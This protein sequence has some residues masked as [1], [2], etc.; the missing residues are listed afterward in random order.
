VPDD[1]VGI[2][3][4][5]GGAIVW[6]AHEDIDP[7][8]SREEMPDEID[9]ELTLNH[10]AGSWQTATIAA[11]AVAYEVWSEALP[12][13][14]G[15]GEAGNIVGNNLDTTVSSRAT[16]T[17]VDTIDSE[18]ENVL[19][20]ADGV[21]ISATAGV[22]GV[23]YPTGTRGQPSS[24]LTDATTIATNAG[25][26][27]F[28]FLDD[29]IYTLLVGY[30]DW[31]FE[32]ESNPSV[33]MNGQVLTGSVFHTGMFLFGQGQPIA[34]FECGFIAANTSG[35]FYRCAI[36]TNVNVIA[37]TNFI[38]C[39]FFGTDLDGAAGTITITDGSGTLTLENIAAGTHDI[40]N[41]NGLLTLN[42]NCVGGTINISGVTALV[43][44]SAGAT[45]NERDSLVNIDTVEQ[46]LAGIHGAGL[47]EGT[48]PAAIDALLTLNHGAGSWQSATVSPSAVAHE[49]WS[50]LLPGSYN[51]GEA[52]NIVG[53]NLDTNVG[54]RSVPGDQMDLVNDAVDANSLA[55]SA[56]QEIDTELTLQ[57]GAGSWQT[58][59]ITVSGVAYE[60]WSELLPGAYGPGEAGNIVGNNLDT[61]VGSRAVPGDEMALVDDAITNAKYDE[62][63]AYPLES[64]DSGATQVART[65]AD[66]DTL[67]TLSDQ[68]DGVVSDIG[69]IS[70]QIEEVLAYADGIYISATTGSGGTSYPTGTRGDPSS[71]IADATTLANTYG[72]RK[73]IFVDNSS[74]TLPQA[75]TDWRFAAE[76]APAINMNGQTL[77]GSIFYQGITL[78]GAGTPAA[79][80]E[81]VL[82]SANTAGLFFRCWFGSS[83]AATGTVEAV[84]CSY[85]NCD[86][87]A[88]GNRNINVYQGNGRLT[89]ENKTSGTHN[90]NDFNG[91]LTLQNTC[92]GGTIIVTGVGNITDN[93]GAGCTVNVDGFVNTELIDDYLAVT[94]G[95]GTGS[96]ETATP[97]SIWSEALPG[98][99]GAGEAG[100]IVGNNLDTNVGS[101]S[102]PG[103][104]MDLVTDAVDADALA[105]SAQA[106]LNTYLEVTANHGAGPWT[107]ASAVDWTDAEKEQIRDSLGVD[108]AKNTAVGGQVQDIEAKI[109]IID[110]NVDTVVADVATIKLDVAFLKQYESGNWEI[111]N[112]QMIFYDTDGVT[113]LRTYNLFNRLGAPADVDTY[114]REKV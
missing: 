26:R 24:N 6:Y 79:C 84:Q 110:T 65:G 98:A 70:D 60:V 58:S 55:N 78:Y 23:A 48:T 64:V 104:Q 96:W 1:A 109:D 46:H 112:N 40:D 51:I 11:S 76:S 107:S 108:G 2:E 44:N 59:S 101:R 95:H 5:T 75:Y 53:N 86:F 80:F 15:A 90:I 102:A 68:I 38:Q 85:A 103:D 47:W 83:M 81:C 106:E 25:V 94:A 32:A 73:F 113:P 105:T 39:S 54:S 16:Q 14:Y 27:K 7:F 72:V 61:N 41:F 45:V 36:S 100:N 9:T 3:W 12:G 91:V 35:T 49:V 10:G 67:E 114:K 17:S 8:R 19:A 82:F 74:Y 97:A 92:T 20:Y 93:S 87:D 69:D 99:Y 52:G 33:N 77:S 31:R 50:E 4:D 57:H 18:I 66:G 89:L 29:S 43:D 22:A 37:A 71:N 30:T 63:T 62:T 111:V 88:G 28:I 13:A 21:Y 34:V 56:V 42:A